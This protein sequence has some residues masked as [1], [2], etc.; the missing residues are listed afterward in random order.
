MT[1]ARRVGGLQKFGE[2]VLPTTKGVRSFSEI[3]RMRF[4]LSKACRRLAEVWKVRFYHRNACRR[5][6][7]LCRERFDHHTACRRLVE[8]RKVT[9]A[10]R[11]GV[12][13]SF[14]EGALTTAKHV[15]SM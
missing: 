6:A 11:L 7:E 5:L 8:V 13:Q 10:N 12:L 3:W 9:T 2:C 15:G 14:G 1:T 4:Y